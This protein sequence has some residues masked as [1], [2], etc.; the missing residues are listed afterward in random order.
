MKKTLYIL[1]VF[2]LLNI[3]LNAQHKLVAFDYEKA[4]FNNNQALPA[5]THILIQGDVP[6]GVTFIELSVYDGK[7]REKRAAL[8]TAIWK[9]PFD[10]E[11][12]RFDLPLNYKLRGSSEYDFKISFFTPI[13]KEEKEKLVN[14]IYKHLDTYLEQTM[15]VSKSSI[16]L[17]RSSRQIMNDLNEIV[18][19]ELENYRNRTAIT[20][21]GFSGI[22]KRNLEQ[23]EK[24]NLNKGRFLFIGKNK[25]ETRSEF[26]SKLVSE[27]KTLI[28]NE[29]NQILDTELAKISDNRLVNDYSTE[30]TR[31]TLAIQ[32]GY[33]GVYIDGD[34]T[35]LTLGSAPFLGLSF[36]F[37]NRTFAPKILSNTSISFGAYLLDFKGA[38]LNNGNVS[39][40][41]FKRPTY[42]GLSY[43]LYQF[44]YLNAGATFLED[45]STAGQISGLQSRVFIRPNVGLSIQI[46]LWADLSR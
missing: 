8:Y 40:P 29:L 17:H 4:T 36:P 30:K 41:I 45:A 19:K 31:R 39:G 6:K 46:N 42:V 38:G 16:K 18:Y 12:S 34:F 13:T 33:G 35:N 24:A 44:I 9:K 26:R 28:N 15:E 5:E 11:S 37:G 1:I 7:G 14:Q 20:F 22:V 32:G 23:I 3:T 27:M 21:Q 10:K 25:E 2:L 43:R